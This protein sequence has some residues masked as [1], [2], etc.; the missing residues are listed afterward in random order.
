MHLP[1]PYVKGCNSGA[2][3]KISWEQLV[4]CLTHSK[5][6]C[7]TSLA[8]YCVLGVHG[9][10]GYLSDYIA[11]PCPTERGYMKVRGQCVKLYTDMLNHTE[12]AAACQSECAH[13]YHFKS[14]ARDS[15]VVANL[16]A[17][18]NDSKYTYSI[19]SSMDLRVGQAG[20]CVYTVL[21]L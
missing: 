17:L 6:H 13:L 8:E 14:L 4:T 3:Q 19:F 10:S 12:A 18:S 5:E 16:T 1:D 15:P 7:K 20:C 11:G 9:R 21:L 2:S